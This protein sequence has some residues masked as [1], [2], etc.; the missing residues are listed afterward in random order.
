MN[1]VLPKMVIDVISLLSIAF[2][3]S[4]SHVNIEV[5]VC[6]KACSCSGKSQ[7]KKQVNYFYVRAPE[8]F[9]SGSEK[10][11]LGVSGME[12]MWMLLTLLQLLIV[13]F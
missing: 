10:A 13:Y 4:T 3:C 9:I 6:G 7:N 1:Y 5:H 2:G 12:I 11:W 8:D